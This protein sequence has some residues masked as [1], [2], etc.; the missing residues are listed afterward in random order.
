MTQTAYDVVMTCEH[1]GKASIGACVNCV[2]DALATARREGYAGGL[3]KALSL[4]CTGFGCHCFD[5]IRAEALPLEKE[6][7]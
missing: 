2:E 7:S 6:K 3:R 5:R 1:L 4:A